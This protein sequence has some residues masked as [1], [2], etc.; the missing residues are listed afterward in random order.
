MFSN[1]D[2]FGVTWKF[3]KKLVSKLSFL[4]NANCEIFE[5]FFILCDL[6]LRTY[7]SE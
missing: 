4:T 2:T 5:S 7:G 6:V 1:F 3:E